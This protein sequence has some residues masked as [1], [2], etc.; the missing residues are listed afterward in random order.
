[1]R[2]N[3][4]ALLTL[5]LLL[6]AVA[7]VFPMKIEVASATSDTG[8]ATEFVADSWIAK[9]AMPQGG[10]VYGAATVNGKIYTFGSYKY[11]ST[12]Y[13]TT[14]E[15]NPVTDTWIVKEQMPTERIDFATALYKNKIFTIGGNRLVKTEHNAQHYFA[16][17]AVEVYDP[18]TN[19]WTIAAPI[20]V[21]VTSIQ[22]NV[23]N[24]KIYVI[25]GTN[26]GMRNITQ[27]YDPYAN[28]W[29]TAADIPKPIYAY[30]SAVL[31]GKIY[32]FGGIEAF[33][34]PSSMGGTKID[35]LAV[36]KTQIYDPATDEWT[37][38]T[39]LPVATI[40]AVA[41]ATTGSYAPK[42]I[43]VIGGYRGIA[44]SVTMLTQVYDPETN[45]W[46]NGT[47][48]RH[49]QYPSALAVSNDTIYI[50]GGMYSAVVPGRSP[51]LP[52]EENPPPPFPSNNYQY[53]PL[54]YGTFKPI[55]TSTPA[56]QP[57]QAAGVLVQS[58]VKAIV[59]AVAVSAVVVASL[60]LYRMHRKNMTRKS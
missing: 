18:A 14:G 33:L 38:G 28:S 32:V 20:P 7:A 42:G 12:V 27:V 37:L 11:N 21:P 50:I 53:V 3:F 6:E 54:G 39:P 25:G 60:L 10:A 4:T 23:I 13:A 16:S 34:T 48:P 22:A 43:Y 55:S 9:T 2:K 59:V 24:D 56:P 30:A 35:M 19:K 31:D 57:T 1:M 41:G 40:L 51:S 52:P 17:E 45:S 49:P 36:N 5:T 8:A 29:F 15:Y 47:E 46:V 44:A 58:S 26:E